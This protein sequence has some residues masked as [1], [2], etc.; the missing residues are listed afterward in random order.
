MDNHEEI[1]ELIASYALGILDDNEAA[2]V[3]SLLETSVEAREELANLQQVTNLLGMAVPEVEPSASFEDRLFDRIGIAE[4]AVPEAP[5]QAPQPVRKPAEPTFWQRLSQMF[6]QPRMQLAGVA[7][8]AFLFVG[9]GMLMRQNAAMNEQLSALDGTLPTLQLAGVGNSAAT[10]LIV[11]SMDGVDGTAIIDLM[12]QPDEGQVYQ[13]WLKKGDL[14]EP[15]P[16]FTNL[17]SEGYGAN[18]VESDFPLD[19]YDQFAVTVEPDGGSDV[20]TSDPV[21]TWPGDE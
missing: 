18:W 13:L 1:Q 8:M 10:G 17:T 21:L 19:S 14:V 12:P 2:Q 7:L 5:K 20:P 15:G 9:S 3:E 11:L 4:T 6:A 16:T